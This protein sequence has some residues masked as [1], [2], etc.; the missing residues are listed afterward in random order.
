MSDVSLNIC[1]IERRLLMTETELE[2]TKLRWR[3][4]LLEAVV[5]KTFSALVGVAGTPPHEFARLLTRGVDKLQK[6]GEAALL[7]EPPLDDQK[8]MAAEFV[9]VCEEMKQSFVDLL[10]EGE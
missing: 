2:L 9:Q 10:E 3:V 8:E 5:V 4:S 1:A 6:D 7:A